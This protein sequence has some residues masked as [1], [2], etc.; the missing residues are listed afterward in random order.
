MSDE[1]TAETPPGTPGQRALGAME[2]AVRRAR[3]S[4]GAPPLPPPPL[5]RAQS[6]PPRVEAAPPREEQRPP[7]EPRETAPRGET[8]PPAR[9]DRWLIGSVTAVAVL[10]V[11]AAVALIVSLSGNSAPP[12]STAATSGQKAT[13]PSHSPPTSPRSGA[14]GATTPSTSAPTPSTS[15]T[16]PVAPA[17]PPVISALSPA[18]GSAGQSVTVSGANFLSTTGQIV[19]TFNGQ[20]A[21]TSCPAQ[22]TCTVTVP[23]SNA[24]SAQVVIT[25]AG[26]ASNAETFTYS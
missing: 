9:L 18:S 14:G 12:P 11:A 23:S 3:E 10:V 8:V 6:T 4:A 5:A 15:T 19:A 13:V 2:S 1:R 26:G 25:T 20:V 22:N 17:G 7:A 16:V 21:P 24:P